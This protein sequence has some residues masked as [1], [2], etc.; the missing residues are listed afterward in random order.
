MTKLLGAP[1]V[2]IDVDRETL[3]VN[4]NNV[5]TTITAKTKSIIPEH[6]CWR[7]ITDG[8]ATCCSA[9]AIISR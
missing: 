5:E 6:Y 2:M 8:C 9:K 3:M 7:T 1:P 4:A